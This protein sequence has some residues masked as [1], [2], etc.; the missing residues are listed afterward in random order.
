MT[1]VTDQELKQGQAGGAI[2]YDDDDADAADLTTESLPA[3]RGAPEQSLPVTGVPYQAVMSGLLHYPL[4]QPWAKG[5]Q[6]ECALGS[7]AEVDPGGAEL[8]AVS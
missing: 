2:N 7:S 1:P 5:H 8:E 6:E 3:Q 4:T